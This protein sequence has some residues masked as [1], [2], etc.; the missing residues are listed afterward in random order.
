[1]KLSKNQ[2]LLS[3]QNSTYF[4]RAGSEYTTTGGQWR[5]IVSATLHP[6]FD[7]NTLDYNIALLKISQNFILGEVQPIAMASPSL[8]LTPG[9]E[10][11][12][13]GWRTNHEITE[14]TLQA[15]IVP[16][17]DRDLCTQLYTGSGFISPSKFCAGNLNIDTD[18]NCIPYSGFPFVVQNVLHGIYAWG[19]QCYSSSYPGVYINI[20]GVRNWINAN[21]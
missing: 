19:F 2:H 12:V 3:F 7:A 14:E 11:A 4:V 9:I 5:E 20:G 13:S 8:L 18:E 16:V 21:L 1:M 10:G 6:Q 15:V 17:V